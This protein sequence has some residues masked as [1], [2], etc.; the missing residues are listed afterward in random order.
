MG[1]LGF[2]VFLLGVIALPAS[3][4][5]PRPTQCV[6]TQHWI[7]LRQA[8]EEAAAC[9]DALLD[10]STTSCDPA[11]PP[12]CA[13]SLVDD[14]VALAYGALPNP[15][16]P[17]DPAILQAQ[18]TCQQAIG[19]A[20]AEYTWEYLRHRINGL[21]EDAAH[22]LAAKELD[23]IP[24]ACNLNVAE[25]GNDVVLPVA[26]PQCGAAAAAPGSAVDGA[27]LADCLGTLLG[28][29]VERIGPDPQPLRPNIVFILTDDQRW[30]SVREEHS[31]DGTPVMPNLLS[32]IADSGVAFTDAFITSPLCAPA[33]ASILTGQYAHTHGVKEGGPDGGAAGGQAVSDDTWRVF[34]IIDVQP[35]GSAPVPSCA[36]P[37]S[38]TTE[39]VVTGTGDATGIS[40]GGGFRAFR[41][42]EYGLFQDAGRW[43]LG[44]KT[45]SGAWERLTGPLRS[46]MDGGLSF[47]Y[48]DAGGNVT[49]DPA[50]VRT[51]EIV[52]RAESFGQARRYGGS[53]P[54]T[55]RQDSIRTMVFLRG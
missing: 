19:T 13:K 35:G 21:S 48:F 8:I 6:E 46:P 17:F 3:G 4:G 53:A 38:P 20:A 42:I 1:L 23:A 29:W 28:V 9:R 30:D 2:G 31:P 14:A 27:A 22:T 49:A 51:V 24:A 5:R 52:I 34:D 18:F 12:G 32:E 45:G 47:T 25:D 15:V 36:W 39:R 40:V 41:R 43:W 33:R 11:T 50:A 44:Q 7:Q 26:G 37:A 16:V 54:P 10:G 55:E